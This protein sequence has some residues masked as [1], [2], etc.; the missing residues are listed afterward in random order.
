MSRRDLF[1]ACQNFRCNVARNLGIHKLNTFKKIIIIKKNS[2]I[3][4]IDYKTDLDPCNLLN[5]WPISNHFQDSRKD[6]S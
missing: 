5:Y 4:T 3:Q 6:Y 1:T 2:S